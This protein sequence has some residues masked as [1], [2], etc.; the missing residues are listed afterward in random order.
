[1]PVWL[2]IFEGFIDLFAL[3]FRSWAGAV[4]SLISLGRAL[5]RLKL[6]WFHPAPSHIVRLCIPSPDRRHRVSGSAFPLAISC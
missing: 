5:Q 4:L 1:M 2:L 6:D 3:T